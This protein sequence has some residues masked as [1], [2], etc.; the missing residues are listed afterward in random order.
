MEFMMKKLEKKN[1]GIFLLE[2][3]N[4]FPDLGVDKAKKMRLWVNQSMVGSGKLPI[5]KTYTSRDSYGNGVGVVW[6]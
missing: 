1:M 3:R 6:K 5:Q 4:V 2:F